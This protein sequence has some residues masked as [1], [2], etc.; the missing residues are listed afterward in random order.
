MAP[1]LNRC[2]KR[3]DLTARERNVAERMVAGSSNG[4]IA[5]AIG[6]SEGTAKFHVA[7]ILKKL[8]TRNRPAAVVVII[9]ERSL[10]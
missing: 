6:I 9:A 4:E 3:L 10:S 2:R 1:H 8:E 7:N 5:M